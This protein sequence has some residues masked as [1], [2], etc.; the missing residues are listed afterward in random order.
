MARTTVTLTVTFTVTL[1]VSLTVCP[2]AV[3]LTAVKEFMESEGA[4]DLIVNGQLHQILGTTSQSV[5]EEAATLRQCA[6]HR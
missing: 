6:V 2:S 4:L 1:T 5:Y 3:R